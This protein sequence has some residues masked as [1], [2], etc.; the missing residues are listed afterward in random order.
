MAV[1]VV[2]PPAVTAALVGQAGGQDQDG[3][4]RPRVLALA[5]A[6]SIGAVVATLG[7]AA[8]AAVVAAVVPA[9]GTR[10]SLADAGPVLLLLAAAAGL[11]HGAADA[12]LVLRGAATRRRA[13]LLLLGYAAVAVVSVL[14]ALAV[15]G[16]AVAVLLVLAVVHFAEGESAFDRLRGGRG[17]LLPGLAVG[18]TVVGLPLLV[19]P[20]DARALLTELSPALAAGL[21]DGPGRAVVALGVLLLVAAGLVRGSAWLRV[22]IGLVVALVATTAPLVA[23][24]VWFAGWHAVRHTARLRA[25][26]SSWRDLVLTT[27]LPTVGGALLLAVLATRVGAAPAVLVGLLA[28]TV[29]HTAVVVRLGAAGRSR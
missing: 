9:A 28:L 11:P 18:A 8:L 29:P 22:E 20:D 10:Y 16:P 17:R 6:L 24:A 25:T 3:V 5:T 21:L 4:R 15:P 12:A 14:V 1:T 27:A 23:F 19:R 7:V 13:A 26:G 2:P